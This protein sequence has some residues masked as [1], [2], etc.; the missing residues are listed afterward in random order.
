MIT[1]A[2]LLGLMM[3]GSTM[4][5]SEAL[6]LTKGDDDDQADDDSDAPQERTPVFGFAYADLLLDAVPADDAA[7]P[8][9]ALARY[10]EDEADFDA[11]AEGA[12]DEP[13][14]PAWSSL[15]DWLALTDGAPTLI[16]EYDEA[17]DALFVVYD[18]AAHPAPVLS[19]GPSETGE[20][21]AML[22]LDGMPLAIVSGGAGLD[23]SM[24]ELVP[25][26]QFPAALA[27]GA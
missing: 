2:S 4:D 8:D 3:V 24:V 20:D 27:A 11:M 15:D 18:A 22:L 16:D 13:A 7:D 1:L 5:F 19:V 17:E 6:D 14:A 10:L 26:A 25:E 23:P 21:D 12:L 9:A